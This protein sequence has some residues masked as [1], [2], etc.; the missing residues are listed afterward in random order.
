[1]GN[2]TNNKTIRKKQMDNLTSEQRILLSQVFDAMRDDMEGN[3]AAK[4]AVAKRLK[5]ELVKALAKNNSEKK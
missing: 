3:G 1:M 4:L 5:G 2:I